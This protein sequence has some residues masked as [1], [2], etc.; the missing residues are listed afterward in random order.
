MN[1]NSEGSKTSKDDL[2]N[3]QMK[4]RVLRK[5]PEVFVCVTI[6]GTLGH[7]LDLEEDS[8]VWFWIY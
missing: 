2:Q 1:V 4:E 8:G 6:E 5:T 3:S 7:G